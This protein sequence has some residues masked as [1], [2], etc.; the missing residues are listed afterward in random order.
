M[1]KIKFL[2]KRRPRDSEQRLQLCLLFTEQRHAAQ[3]P[4]DAVGYVDP[5]QKQQRQ[6]QHGYGA[7][8]GIG[9]QPHSV[10]HRLEEGRQ[11]AGPQL[12]DDKQHQHQQQHDGVLAA[13][14]IDLQTP[15]QKS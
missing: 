14:N 13:E 2:F 8:R 7:Q 10:T 3:Q 9:Q 12:V 6:C 1:T 15:P 11:G 5:A 4:V